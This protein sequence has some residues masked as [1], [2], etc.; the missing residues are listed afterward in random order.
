MN[1]SNPN[2]SAPSQIVT[3]PDPAF[4]QNL[5]C[6][7][8]LRWNFVFQRPQHLLTRFSSRLK[9]DYVEEPVFDAAG[10][11]PRLAI[12]QVSPTLQVLVPHLPEGISGE[13]VDL[14]QRR[15]IDE[16]FQDKNLKDFIFWYYTPM[17]LS[18]TEHL[19]PALV[20]YDCMDELSAFM[21]APV[22]LLRREE[23]LFRL[24]DVVFTGGHSL[25]ESKKRRHPSVH[26]FPSSI[27]KDHFVKAR[28]KGHIPP[29]LQQQDRPVLGFAGVLDERLDIQLL[30]NI[31]F[32]RPSWTIILVGPIVKIDPALLPDLPNLVITGPKNYKDLPD[33]L[34]GWDLGLIPF[35]LNES[36]RFI[37]PTKT[38]EYLAA[39]LP[40]ISTPIHDVIHRYAAGEMVE[41]RADAAGF[42]RAVEA[43]L[44]WS[45]QEYQSW[46]RRVDKQLAGESWD[47]TY[48]EMLAA[49]QQAL[50]LKSAPAKSAAGKEGDLTMNSY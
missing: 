7:S 5:V 35:L 20:L 15:L 47:D 36:T 14:M 38:P 50:L 44:A 42:I 12:S 13:E 29:E 37:S 28:E 11:Q 40:V 6:F 21:N 24:A 41:I 48:A 3:S 25:Y 31:A 23:A 22:Q 18:F 9:V 10:T 39:G 33:Y 46:L 49:A 43:I 34:R 27:D 1:I 19:Q 16:Y 17:A 8:H 26:L 30:A 4:P 2:P 32:A 45:P